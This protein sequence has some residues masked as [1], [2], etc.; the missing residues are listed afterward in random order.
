MKAFSYFISFWILLVMLG[1]CASKKPT[2]PVIVTKTKTIKE[3]V[4]DTVFTVKADSSF[5][6]AYIECVN[7]KPVILEQKK[8]DTTVAKAGSYLKIPKVKL[9]ESG[10]LEVNCEAEAQKL[11]ASWKETYIHE[12]EPVIVEKPVPVEKPYPWY[13]TIQ[14]WFGRILL[15]MLLLILIN[16][17]YKTS[18]K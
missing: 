9:S 14:L 3:V 5:Y 12:Q 11:F 16:F 18:K 7:G 2:D 10:V 6:R 17:L 8:N 15:A 13:V 4:K 1:S